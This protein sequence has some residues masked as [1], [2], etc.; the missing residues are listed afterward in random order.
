MY[1]VVGMYCVEGADDA[2]SSGV[3]FGDDAPGALSGDGAAG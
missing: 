1:V 3:I 2:H